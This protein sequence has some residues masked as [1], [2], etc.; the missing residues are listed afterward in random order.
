[1]Q[2]LNKS[3]SGNVAPLPGLA[4]LKEA[5]AR[6]KSKP[7]NMTP[8]HSG[9]TIDGINLAWFI[10]TAAEL[11]SGKWNPRPVRVVEIPKGL[12][13]LDRIAV[14]DSANPGTKLRLVE[15]DEASLTRELGVPEPRDK[16]VQEAL[17]ERIKKRLGKAQS[18][19]S[20]GYRDGIGPREVS[21]AIR[22]WKEPNWVIEGDIKG[23][24]D[25]VD[26]TIL[27]RYLKTRG[28]GT[29]YVHTVEKILKAGKIMPNG[30]FKPTHKGTPQ[31]GTISPDLANLYLTPFDRWVERQRRGNWQTYGIEYVR[32]A[33]DWVIGIAGQEW[34]AIE[35]K[36]K[37]GEYLRKK[38]KLELSD[39]KTKIT[40]ARKGFQF[41][42]FQWKRARNELLNRN[43]KTRTKKNLPA[44]II[45]IGDALMAKEKYK[46][47]ALMYAAIRMTSTGKKLGWDFKSHLRAL[48]D[49]FG[50]LRTSSNRADVLH[51]ALSLNREV[52]LRQLGY[53]GMHEF[54]KKQFPNREKLYETWLKE[55]QDAA[56]R[57]FSTKVKKRTPEKRQPYMPSLTVCQLC[58]KNDQ[59]RIRTVP[60]INPKPQ[61]RLEETTKK[62]NRKHVAACKSCSH[63]LD[64]P[65]TRQ[66]P[67]LKIGQGLAP[68][69]NFGQL[70]FWTPGAS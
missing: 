47:K 62:L 4:Q 66:V 67:I 6:I 12:Q 32:Y 53:R 22:K 55:S 42:G 49:E 64:T 52:K 16:I 51:E 34:M 3:A 45:P 28:L 69:V 43:W 10:R 7:G 40:E 58:Q 56:M 54:D 2:Q 23:Y 33:D 39:A 21:E 60:R 31:G 25:N 27:L 36:R 9:E 11:Q 5:Y 8:G 61:T 35:V 44:K 1:M 18:R 63:E 59:T 57:I 37:V 38:L 68:G 30:E 26:H 14:S 19:N 13:G 70:K 20:F 46:F 41:L 24:F 65:I 17:R 15:P 50:H 48:R 29:Q